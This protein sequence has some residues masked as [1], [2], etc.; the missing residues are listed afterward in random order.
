MLTHFIS[1]MIM[2]HTT[3]RD[4]ETSRVLLALLG[5]EQPGTSSASAGKTTDKIKM[6]HRYRLGTVAL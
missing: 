1:L 2:A 4:E 5:A 6:P 3:Y